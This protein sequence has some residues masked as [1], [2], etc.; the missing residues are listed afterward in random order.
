M[1]GL[2]CICLVIHFGGKPTR[3]HEQAQGY[4]NGETLYGLYILSL[5]PHCDASTVHVLLAADLKQAVSQF[6]SSYTL[7]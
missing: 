7:G 3:S 1:L 2:L 6:M 4:V 5:I